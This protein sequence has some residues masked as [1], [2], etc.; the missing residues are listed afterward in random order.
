MWLVKIAKGVEVT[1][2]KFNEH[3][4]SYENGE[5]RA[6]VAGQVEMA[7]AVINHEG[8]PESITVMIGN[9]W[10]DFPER[11]IEWKKLPPCSEL[12]SMF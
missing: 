12:W 8:F 1:P 10:Y 7:R 4:D 3:G 11:A 9:M 6:F 5:A 2:V